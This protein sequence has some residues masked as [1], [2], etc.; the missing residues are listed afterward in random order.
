MS[1]IITSIYNCPVK[2][3]SFQNIDKCKINKK[4]VVVATKKGPWNKT[5]QEA[6]SSGG[7]QQIGQECQGL[8]G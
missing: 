5:C 1:A 7:Q 3:I 8:R 6:Q 2:S 4:T